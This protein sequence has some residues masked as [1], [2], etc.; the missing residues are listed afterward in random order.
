MTSRAP[1]RRSKTEEHPEIQCDECGRWVFVDGTPF[2]DV[3]SA[4]EGGPFTCK[5]CEKLADVNVRLTGLECHRDDMLHSKVEALEALVQELTVRLQ[6]LHRVHNGTDAA[7]D[8]DPNRE[9]PT[10]VSLTM[11]SQHGTPVTTHS[12]TQ[13]QSTAGNEASTIT[14]GQDDSE[15]KQAVAPPATLPVAVMADHNEVTPALE[16]S[17][18]LRPAPPRH[19]QKRK[20]RGTSGDSEQPPKENGSTANA[21]EANTR[22]HGRKGKNKRSHC[23]NQGAPQAGSRRR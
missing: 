2:S 9:P 4:T 12:V 17:G 16:N 22:P 11:P 21:E 6:Q 8:V 20:E 3:A 23:P 5:L 19:K 10:N 18:E 7:H 14:D 13:P 1:T 15:I